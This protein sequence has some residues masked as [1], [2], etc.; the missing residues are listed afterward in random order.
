MSETTPASK[1]ETPSTKSQKSKFVG[2]GKKSKKQDIP[3]VTDASHDSVKDLLEKN[4]KW[5][6]IIYEQNRKIRRSLMWNAI[7]SWIR[8]LIFV[9]PFVIAGVYLWPMYKNAQG[10]LFDLLTGVNPITQT[11][12]Q[13]NNAALKSLMKVLPLSNEQQDQI[14]A[15]MDNNNSPQ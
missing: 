12:V 3:D 10:Q 14:N 15:L 1:V 2:A 13:D 4:L 5:S 6:Q 9:I 8:I 7:G 11:S